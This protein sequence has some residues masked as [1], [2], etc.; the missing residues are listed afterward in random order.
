[1]EPLQNGTKPYQVRAREAL[2]ILVRQARA[3]HPVPYKGLA[4]E[5]GMPNP[6]N[7]NYPLGLIGE[8]LQE[9]G[10][11]WEQSIPPIQFLVLNKNK[12]V[13]G[14][15]VT[16]Y[17]PGVPDFKTLSLKQKRALLQVK[18]SEIYAFPRWE[19]VLEA[20]GLQPI[21][22]G[23]TEE[24]ATHLYRLGVGGEESEAHRN[25]KNF[26]ASNPALMNPR[27]QVFAQVEYQLPSG[28]SIDVLFKGRREWIGIEVKA[29]NAPHNEIARGVFQCVKYEA[30]LRAV[31]AV[32]DI[33]AEVRVALVIEGRFPEALISLRNSLGVEV[34]DRAYE[35]GG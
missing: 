5:L 28:D 4:D 2:P 31:L 12:G 6:R 23:F 7:L 32:Q 16:W 13:P 14:D 35:Q 9:L 10:H 33:E 30:L 21:R 15:A 8:A 34:I 26:V 27:E 1:M 19:D 18:L 17:V 24:M 20:L 22:L 25:L 3:E 29:A 11:L